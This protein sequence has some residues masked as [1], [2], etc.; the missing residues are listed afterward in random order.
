V[1]IIPRCHVSG[2][3]KIFKRPT[4]LARHIDTIHEKKTQYWCPIPTC[5]RHVYYL[6]DAKPFPRKDKRNEHF[7]KVHKNEGVDLA[8]FDAKLA[9]DIANMQ[10]PHDSDNPFPVDLH[11]FQPAEDNANIR[12]PKEFNYSLAAGMDGF[13]PAEGVAD[14]QF[15]QEFDNGFV[16]DMNGF[17]LAADANGQ[18]PQAPA[19]NAGVGMGAFHPTENIASVPLAQDSVD[20]FATGINGYQ[21]AGQTAGAQRPQEFDGASVASMGGNQH[22]EATAYGRLSQGFDNGFVAEMDDFQF[23]GDVD[24]LQPSQEFEEASAADMY[25][26]YAGV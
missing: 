26:F 6:D 9:E 24:S 12:S 7:R 25:G 13:E 16:S 15:L 10:N 5:N 22:A 23:T 1:I 14:I 18:L 2:C 20:D 17:Q 11:G 3:S 8:A 4:D 19:W 21:Y